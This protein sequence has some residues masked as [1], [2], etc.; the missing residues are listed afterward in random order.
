MTQHAQFDKSYEQQRL[1]ASLGC[2]FF[3]VLAAL[4]VATGLYGTHTFRVNRRTAEIGIRM[5]LGASRSQVLR[6]VIVENLSILVFG[7]AAGIPLTQLAV[8]P[9]KAM[10]YEISPIRSNGIRLGDRCTCSGFGGRSTDTGSPRR[11]RRSDSSLESGMIPSSGDKQRSMIGRSYSCNCHHPPPSCCGGPAVTCIFRVRF[12]SCCQPQRSME[13]TRP[14][15]E[16]RVGSVQVFLFQQLLKLRRRSQGREILVFIETFAII[17][18]FI[19]CLTEIEER[20]LLL[21]GAGERLC[22]VVI[23]GNALLTR[24]ATFHHLGLIGVKDLFVD[25]KGLLIHLQPFLEFAFRKVGGAQIAVSDRT[26]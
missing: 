5:A 8:R 12:F 22:N 18:A 15:L 2:C 24:A 19:H 14:A 21:P 20:L 26:F 25:G 4:L 23:D 10:L 17:E 11:F 3:G 7:L 1:F 9:L 6:I 16:P 13:T